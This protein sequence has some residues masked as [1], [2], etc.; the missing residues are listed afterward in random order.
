MIV[1]HECRTLRGGFQVTHKENENDD[2]CIGVDSRGRHARVR[3][4]FR[5]GGRRVRNQPR[6]EC[7]PATAL[8]ESPGRQSAGANAKA[9]LVFPK[10]TKA[11]LG[12]GGQY[13]DGA[14]L[15]NGKAV[16]YYNTAGA[17]FGLQAGAQQFGYAMFF[18]N[19]KALPQLD[20]P[21]A[22]RSASARPSS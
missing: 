1:I 2:E 3:V 6:C 17:S 13:G 16:G 21:R 4:S 22:S 15:Q 18:M 20:G 11:G 8:R 19:A 9:I 14:L 5:D 10:V 7:E 12:V